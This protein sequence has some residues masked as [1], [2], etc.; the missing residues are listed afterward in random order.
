MGMNMNLPDRKII[1]GLLA[2]IALA[3]LAIL[4]SKVMPQPGAICL[5]ILIGMVAGNLMPEDHLFSAGFDFADHV[6]LPAAIAL[7]GSEL[8]LHAMGHTGMDAFLVAIPAMLLAILLALPFG[9][10]LGFSGHTSLMLGIGNSVCGSSAVL[11]AAPALKVRK[12]EVPVA[13]AAVNLMGTVGMFVLPGLAT[14]LNLSAD[15][16]A[17][18]IGGSLQAVGQVAAS[19]FAVSST[20]GDH[21]LVVKM[22]RVL[23]IGPLVMLL[24]HLFQTPDVAGK[25]RL[26]RLPSYI[27]GFLFFAVLASLLPSGHVVLLD[28]RLTAKVLMV[29]AMVAVGS[30]IRFRSL[31]VHGPKALLLVGGLSLIQTGTVLLLLAWRH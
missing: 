2:A 28:I 24:H 26:P 9:R 23:M 5:A 29:V 7:M 11:A 17:N 15:Q 10:L 16:T 21:A 19:G 22:L 8:E 6:I 3:V 25:R 27:L 1:P 4:V 30:R 14:A 31:L 18:L 13:I 20:V 12:H